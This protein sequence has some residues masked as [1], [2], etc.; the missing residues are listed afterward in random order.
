MFRD[1]MGLA[2]LLFMLGSFVIDDIDFVD[3]GLFYFDCFE[4]INQ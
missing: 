4:R 2:F 1:W 3:N